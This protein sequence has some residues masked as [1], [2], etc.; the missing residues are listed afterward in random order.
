MIIDPFYRVISGGAVNALE[1]AEQ[2]QGRP[3]QERFVSHALV[4]VRSYRYLPFGTHSAVLLDISLSGF[5]LEFTGE[6]AAA[7]GK[8]YW[9]VI[10]LAPL[11]IFAPKRLMCKVECR[12]FDEKRY[13]IGGVF[14]SLSKT[15]QLL[16]EQTIESLRQHGQL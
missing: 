6:V 13:R 9:L 5:K 12:W 15:D 1:K 2:E 4:E 8:Q 10:P 11:G 7:P 16:V 14:M 3:R